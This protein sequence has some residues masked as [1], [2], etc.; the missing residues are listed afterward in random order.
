MRFCSRLFPFRTFMGL[1][2][3]LPEMLFCCTG[4]AQPYYVILIMLNFYDFRN[5][6]IEQ[7]VTESIMWHI[8][9]PLVNSS[10]YSPYCNSFYLY[11][12]IF[13]VLTV[14]AILCKAELDLVSLRQPTYGNNGCLS[15]AQ[16]LIKF[17]TTKQDPVLHHCIVYCTIER[18]F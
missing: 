14:V 1:E 16:T 9:R 12:I 11:T 5:L 15:T 6:L 17:C 7:I 3:T 8:V 18:L 10:L 2:K 13:T 4:I